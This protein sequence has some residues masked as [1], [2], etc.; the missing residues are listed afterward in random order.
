[1]N[2]ICI[3]KSHLQ[4]DRIKL[5]FN[6][7]ISNKKQ[8][9][10]DE[11]DKCSFRAQGEDQN[12][13]AAEEVPDE[14]EMAMSRLHEA[15]EQP[16]ACTGDVQMAPADPPPELSYPDYSATE[17]ML[18]E[19]KEMLPAATS[20]KTLANDWYS[21]DDEAAPEPA[22]PP[23]YVPVA[24]PEPPPV[25]YPHH[26]EEEVQQQ[27]AHVVEQHHDSQSEIHNPEKK[28]SIFKSRRLLTGGP[29][30]RFALY[31]HKW[32][33]DKEEKEKAAAAAA[34]TAS[35]A[36]QEASVFDED[37]GETPVLTRVTRAE[38]G[39]EDGE[40]VTGVMCNKAARKV[41]MSL[42]LFCLCNSSGFF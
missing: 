34:Q 30:K 10:D 27:E 9:Q 31:K 40:D 6:I 37:F 18:M 24:P 17:K 1:M 21:D 2:T 7:Y 20:S 5:F 32:T 41:T 12:P 3:Y 13:A 36:K 39:T 33:D 35:V 38:Q 22:L 16:E 26:Q 42:I 23:A 28:G 14:I 15:A 8:A 11:E 4:T 19:S 29:K 25:H